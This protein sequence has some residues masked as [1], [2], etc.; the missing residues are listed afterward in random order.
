MRT[1]RALLFITAIL[2]A[3]LFTP[4]SALAG[5]TAT[6]TISLQVTPINEIAVNGNPGL[7]QVFTSRNEAGPR[8]VIDSSTSYSFY[9]NERNRHITGVISEA[10]PAHTTLKV[11]LA[12]PAGAT[13]CGDVVL[14]TSPRVLVKDAGCKMGSALPIVYRFSAT[15]EAGAVPLTTRTVIFTISE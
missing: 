6:Q 14:S 1:C 11:R 7:M 9:S 8:E 15:R 3:C 2:A 4:V 13:S 5:T 12:A 10:T